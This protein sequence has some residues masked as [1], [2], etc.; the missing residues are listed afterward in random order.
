MKNDDIIIS[1]DNEQS[2]NELNTMPN[3][4]QIDINDFY[5]LLYLAYKNVRNEKAVEIKSKMMK[6]PTDEELKKRSQQ[7]LVLKS[8]ESDKRRPGWEL[9]YG[10]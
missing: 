1:S 8:K 5:R 3:V 2:L 7:I 4:V 9:L 10:K 6:Q